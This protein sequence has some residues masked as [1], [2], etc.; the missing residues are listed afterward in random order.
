MP[1]NRPVERVDPAEFK[2]R[3]RGERLETN[4]T[5]AAAALQAM[6]GATDD[7]QAR[8]AVQCI[9]DYIASDYASRM[10]Q[11]GNDTAKDSS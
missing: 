5:R 3:L 6:T 11:Q 1:D 4:L 8:I 9:A 2:A 7:T 10:Q